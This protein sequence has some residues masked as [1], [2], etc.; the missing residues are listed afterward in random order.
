MSEQHEGLLAKYHVERLS[1]PDGKHDGCRYFVLDPQHD[2]IARR[3]LRQYAA[4]AGFEGNY[5]LRGDL[6]Q[7]LDSIEKEAKS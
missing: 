7:W 6:Y 1:D 5:A 3:A 4:T 2:P